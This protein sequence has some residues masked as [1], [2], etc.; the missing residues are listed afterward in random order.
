MNTVAKIILFTA[1]LHISLSS[2]ATSANPYA[3]SNIPKELLL[4]ANAV[5]RN[6]QMIQ[7]IEDIFHSHVKVKHTTTLLNDKASGYRF[8]RIPYNKFS[9]ISGIKAFVYDSEGKLLPGVR[10]DIRDV[11]GNFG[12]LATDSRY[13]II[14]CPVRKYPFTIEIEYE[15]TYEGPFIYDNWSFQSQPDVSVEQ[16]G[17]QLIVKKGIGFRV[18]GQNLK[19]PCDT[20]SFE[21]RNVYTWQEEKIPAYKKEEMFML[22]FDQNSPAI[23]LTPN[24]FSMGGMKGSMETWESTGKFFYDL[25]KDR[26]NISPELQA[27]LRQLIS[28]TTDGRERVRKIFDYL[29]KNT[30]YVSIQLGVGGYQTL[31]ASFVEKKGYGDC[32]ALTNYMK[33]ML[34]SAGIKSYQA[35]I[36]SGEDQDIIPGFPGNQFDHVI[37]C[38]P[39][40]KDTV[41]LECTNQTIPFDYLG[42]SDGNKHVLL[43]TEN[44]GKLVRTPDY[45]TIDNQTSSYF[46]V[47]ID[48]VGGATIR[49][50]MT[51][52]GVAYETPDFIMN[53]SKEDREQYINSLFASPNITINN[54]TY[55]KDISIY[56]SLTLNCNISADDFV[57]RTKKRMVFN[58]YL[59]DPHPYLSRVLDKDF[60]VN[61]TRV[62]ADTVMYSFPYGYSPEY[63]PEAVIIE[64]DFGKFQSQCRMIGE[65][66]LFTRKFEYYKKKYGKEESQDFVD[67][68]NKIADSN[69]QQILLKKD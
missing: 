14:S 20:F 49:G 42:E 66:I 44:G 9:R 17:M 48:M 36:S 26:D 59:F 37:L 63:I 22:S 23:F 43:L 7:T 34:K 18:L 46:N 11:S 2:F 45:R 62:A 12:E 55:S 6:G 41:W 15:Q 54:L 56:P 28:T 29:Q 52:H 19:H 69:R 47:N 25:N 51:F 64:S 13:W 40:E 1:A 5:V 57:S 31:E 68:V 38:V 58:P 65:K 32:K 8:Y 39:L 16:S 35:L 33:A 10:P 30:R 4:D 61:S 60:S 21:D 53:S 50:K 27:K 24:E 3:V 67:F